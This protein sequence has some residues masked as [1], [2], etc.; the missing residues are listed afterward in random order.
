MLSHSLPRL[1]MRLLKWTGLALSLLLLSIIIAIS[2]MIESTS[3]QP[4]ENATEEEIGCLRAHV[5]RLCEH[6]RYG[7]TL[8]HARNYIESELRATGWEVSRQEFTTSDG[9]THYNLCAL[10]RGSSGRRYIIG[11][12]YDACD[13]D[14]GNPGADDN[15]SAVAALLE[16]AARLPREAPTHDIELVAWACE[17]PPWFETEDMGSAH[18]ASTC[19]P[20]TVAGLICL[21]MLGYYSDAPG[22][23]PTLFPGQALLLPTVGNFIAVVGNF[24]ARPF[25]R[26]VYADLSN[27]MPAL[28]LNVPW[29]GATELFFSDHRN[30]HP[31]GIPSVMVTD[32]AMLRNPNYHEATD[33]PET[34]DYNR[35][36]I[37]TRGLIR[38]VTKLAWSERPG[39]SPKKK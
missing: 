25:A 12:H 14:E 37:V 6:P 20:E 4:G 23:Q 8:E 36:G 26:Q 10:R 13:T 29:A 35:L 28:R 7:A 15:A 19:E 39:D 2:I 1:A 9:E 24:E 5:T 34:L 3:A 16:L 11:A 18:H 21:E 33:T 27:E 38:C 32:T 22:S 17:E 31:L 30:Y